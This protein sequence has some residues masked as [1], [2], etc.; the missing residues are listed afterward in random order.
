[1]EKY[2]LNHK[3]LY[4][5]TNLI[6]ENTNRIYLYP[7]NDVN[8]QLI[9]HSIKVTGDPNIITHID[10]FN[11]RV[12]FFNYLKPHDSMMISSEAEIVVKEFNPI[13]NKNYDKNDW[14]ILRNYG[15]DINLIPYLKVDQF[16]Q[17]KK[18]N[19]FFND[20]K[21]NNDSVLDF[22]NKIC[23]YVYKNFEYKKG[24]TDVYSTTDQVWKLK[25]GVCQDF[26]NVLIQIYRLVNIPARYVSGYI[27]AKDGLV[28]SGATHAW[29]EIFIPNIGWYGIDPTNN[30]PV[31]IY[32][33]KLAVGKGY[34]DCSP[35][36]GV[37]KG[38]EKQEMK[39]EV[40]LDTKPKSKNYESSFKISDNKILADNKDSFE[41]SFIKSQQIIQQQQ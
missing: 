38:N 17:K 12:G 19:K 8:Q 23:E 4:T 37:F 30:C 36:K 40:Y 11:N 28:G 34:Q 7:Y 15:F 14:N 39:V 10:V 33:I 31:G 9:S 26:S 16:F 5:Y 24:I 1:M 13:N 22:S 29:V 6:S 3:T 27:Y 18:F 20:L 21:D 41:N 35:V 32:H 2:Y 25:S